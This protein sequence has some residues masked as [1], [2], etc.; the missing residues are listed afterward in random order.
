MVEMRERGVLR[1]LQATPVSALSLV[2]AYL[3]VNV[4][5]CLLQSALIV[6][7]GVLVLGVPLALAERA[8][9]SLCFGVGSIVRG[10]GDVPPFLAAARLAGNRIF[11]REPAA[12]GSRVA[13]R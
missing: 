5:N 3:I 4:F 6:A 1:R 2:S 8:A 9:G 13:N 10:D 12:V 11:W 7:A